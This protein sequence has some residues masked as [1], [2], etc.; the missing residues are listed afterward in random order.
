MIQALLLSKMYYMAG[1]DCTP[2]GVCHFN[3]PFGVQTLKIRSLQYLY[4]FWCFLWFSAWGTNTM[5]STVLQVFVPQAENTK[6]PSTKPRTINTRSTRRL[7]L[8]SVQIKS[9][10][11]QN[12]LLIM[13][14]EFGKNLPRAD[15]INFFFI[16]S[17]IHF[18]L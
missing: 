9:P 17:K 2:F 14:D 4:P 18:D 5:K 15:V 7:P 8:K 12:G 1:L 16:A 13:L 6:T 10:I 3:T 11:F